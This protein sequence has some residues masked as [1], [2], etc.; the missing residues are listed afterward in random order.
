MERLM[1][2]ERKRD[3]ERGKNNPKHVVDSI[4]KIK[5]IYVAV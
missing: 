3:S 5:K 4:T 2:I 1:D